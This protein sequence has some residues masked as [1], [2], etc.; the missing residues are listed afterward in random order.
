MRGYLFYT[1]SYNPIPLYLFCYSDCSHCSYTVPGHNPHRVFYWALAYFLAQDVLG[2]ES[3][4]SP[5]ILGSFDWKMVLETK[6]WVLGVLMAHGT[7]LLLGSLSWQSKKKYMWMNP[8]PSIPM[9]TYVCMHI[10]CVYAITYTHRH[11]HTHSYL[12]QCVIRTYAHWCL[13]ALIHLALGSF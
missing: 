4:I 3:A 1:S 6:I 12:L 11:T 9:N 5:R 7:S 10:V 13:T 8:K 2:L